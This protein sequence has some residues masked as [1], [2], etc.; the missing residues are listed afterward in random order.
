MTQ[1]LK[2]RDSISNYFDRILSGIGKRGSSFSD[3]DA[4][5]HDRDTHRFLVQEF[6]HEGE[7]EKNAAQHWM[8][9]DLA[10]LPDHFT[11]WHVVKRHD[12]RIGFAPFGEDPRVI[13]VQEYQA[14][15]AAW[16]ADRAFGAGAAVPAVCTTMPLTKDDIA[17]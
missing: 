2:F 8:L 5:T 15:F 17:W 9:R 14:R 16:W 4:V 11:V 7:D 6:K 10:A 12:G 3:I 13:T 1:L